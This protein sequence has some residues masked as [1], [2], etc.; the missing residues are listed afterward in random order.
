MGEKPLLIE[1]GKMENE[2]EMPDDEERCS[3]ESSDMENMEDM[4]IWDWSKN[5]TKKLAKWLR[6]LSETVTQQVLK[7]TSRSRMDY[8]R[9]GFPRSLSL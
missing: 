7:Y 4:V 5:T 3:E 1:G 8:L 2:N 6:T 9:S